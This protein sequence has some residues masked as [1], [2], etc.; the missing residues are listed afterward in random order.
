MSLLKLA[1]VVGPRNRR[2]VG[3]RSIR[4]V[5]FHGA[6]D[7]LEEVYWRPTGCIPLRVEG[8]TSGKMATPVPTMT[9]A[10]IATAMVIN[11]SIG[12]KI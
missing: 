12:T 1:L 10:P 2:T 3:F 5:G 4:G 11:V 8:T 9:P 6:V 7:D